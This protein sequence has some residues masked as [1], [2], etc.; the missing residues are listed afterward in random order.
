MIHGLLT[1][2]G[3]L[4]VLQGFG[5]ALV[6]RALGFMLGPNAALPTNRTWTRLQG[7]GMTLLGASFVVAATA[8]PEDLGLIV[9]VVAL[10]AVACGMFV[11]ALFRRSRR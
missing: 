3:L 6:P 10:S 11:M 7:L 1:L 8:P 9:T 5:L 4:V 2:V